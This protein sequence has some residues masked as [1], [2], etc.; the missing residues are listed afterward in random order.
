M[1]LIPA[2][3]RLQVGL[4]HARAVVVMQLIP[5]RGRLRWKI[6]STEKSILD[7]AYPREGTVIMYPWF[8]H[9]EKV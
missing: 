8:F 4:E 2:R 6:S 7:A 1:Q 9:S 3:G 5:A